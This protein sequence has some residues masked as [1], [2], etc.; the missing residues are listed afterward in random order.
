MDADGWA[1]PGPAVVVAPGST[2]GRAGEE[3]QLS[4]AIPRHFGK[5]N[6]WVGDYVVAHYSFGPQDAA[7]NE[8]ADVL[9]GYR[10]LA[11]CPNPKDFATPCA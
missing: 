5:R 1:L 8:A 6:L 2:P 10:A 7:L 9:E 11:G 4:Y 3:Q